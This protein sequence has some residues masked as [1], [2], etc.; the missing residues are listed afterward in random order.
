MVSRVLLNTT[1]SI[2]FSL[3]AAFVIASSENGS[4]QLQ[5]LGF[6]VT[7]EADGKSWPGQVVMTH[8][9]W[10]NGSNLRLTSH[11]SSP[12]PKE[13]ELPEYEDLQEDGGMIFT[14][15]SD[16]GELVRI[17][18]YGTFAH[19]GEMVGKLESFP[20]GLLQ[21]LDNR[22]YLSRFLLLE[23][24]AFVRGIL[25]NHDSEGFYYALVMSDNSEILW[26]LDHGK[27]L[28]GI[29]VKRAGKSLSYRVVPPADETLVST[30]FQ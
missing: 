29:K 5:S 6:Q 15:V 30:A 24:P 23:E 18:E 4:S 26:H 27:G 21:P 10:F 1:Y 16:Q 19:M 13:L 8:E 7:L 14:K 28:K 9:K 17:T 20:E 3:A 12:P 2:A 22:L 11:F 25:S